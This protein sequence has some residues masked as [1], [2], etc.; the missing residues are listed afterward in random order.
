M[1]DK[2]ILI[3]YAIRDAQIGQIF[4]DGNGGGVH[5]IQGASIIGLEEAVAVGES[6][7]SVLSPCG[8]LRLGG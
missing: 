1:E 7:S 4:Q 5:E 2:T 3:A 6:T 8:I